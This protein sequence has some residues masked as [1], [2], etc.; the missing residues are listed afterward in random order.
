MPGFSP[1]DAEMFIAV[2]E[3][4]SCMYWFSLFRS[5]NIATS[6]I[7]KKKLISDITRLMIDFMLFFSRLSQKSRQIREL[8]AAMEEY[9]SVI[10]VCVCVTAYQHPGAVRIFKFKTL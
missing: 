3:K 1:N 5:D 10:E 9:S 8:K 7:C 2:L 6:D 4:I